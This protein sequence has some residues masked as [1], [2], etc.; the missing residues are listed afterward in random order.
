MVGMFPIQPEFHCLREIPGADGAAAGRTV[1]EEDRP[2]VGVLAIVESAHTLP[3]LALGEEVA[4]CFG[5]E[6]VAVARLR[7]PQVRLLGRLQ[8]RSLD[9]RNDKSG[10]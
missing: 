4:I 9:A 2:E 7:D 10:S 6:P 5:R 8:V 3:M 1:A